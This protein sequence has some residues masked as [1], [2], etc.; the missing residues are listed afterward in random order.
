VNQPTRAEA[1]VVLDPEPRG[2]LG[3]AVLA[4]L[5]AVGVGAVASVS[6]LLAVPAALGAVTVLWAWRVPTFA[7]VLVVAV[8]P[9]LSG[10]D[11]LGGASAGLKLSEVVLIAAA[12]AVALRRPAGLSRMQG[13]DRLLLIFAVAGIGF[14]AFHWLKE[15]SELSLAIRVGLQPALLYLTWWTASRSIRDE[16]GL[17]TVVRFALLASTVPAG[18]AVLQGFGAPGVRSAVRSVV[19]SPWPPLPGAPGIPRVTGPFPIWHSLI[20]YLLPP[21]VV[22]VAL[23]LRQH[24]SVLPS[25][26]LV[27]VVLVD[28]LALVLSVTVT[29][30]LWVVISVLLVGQFQRRLGRSALVLAAG[31][32]AVALLLPGPVSDRVDQQTA[33]Q[34]PTTHSLVPQTLSYRIEVWQRDFL[35]LVERSVPYGI[36]NELPASVVFRHPENGFLTLILRGGFLYLIAAVTALVAAGLAL[37]RARGVRGLVGDLA[38]ALLAVL[39][40][41]PLASMV[42][43]Y[44]SNAGFPQSW[45]ALAGAT[46]GA[47]GA[48]VRRPWPRSVPD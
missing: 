1:G 32:V 24:R 31:V 10:I 36:G 46:V 23:L 14:A 41:L 43:P 39:L 40:V 12:A 34:S 26:L 8:C 7:G 44:L 38:G 2:P 4:V 15:G 25:G 27:C 9:A 18:I 22:A 5:I 37:A 17:R 35:P 33:S 20:A 13:V 19:S 28:G 30:A 21:L 48:V 45:T 3:P 11:R 16:A 29:A 42:W 6:P 47:A